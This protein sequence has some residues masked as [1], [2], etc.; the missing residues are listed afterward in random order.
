[1]VS[2]PF[3]VKY[4][5]LVSSANLLRIHSISLSKSLIKMLNS[6]VPKMDARRMSN[7]SV[8]VPGAGGVVWSHPF[9]SFPI[10]PIS[11]IE[12]LSLPSFALHLS[13]RR[14]FHFYSV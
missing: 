1:M 13:M 14:T 2:L 5:S 6:T 7:M 4:N 10:V 8:W 11:Q 12:A 9:L 3:I